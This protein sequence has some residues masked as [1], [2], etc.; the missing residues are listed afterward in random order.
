MRGSRSPSTVSIATPEKP[1]VATGSR[2]LGMQQPPQPLF[3]TKFKQRPPRGRCRG[4]GAP[5]RGWPC[6]DGGAAPRPGAAIHGT[7]PTL[8][9]VWRYRRHFYEARME[10]AD[11]FWKPKIQNASYG[12]S[13]SPRL[14]RERRAVRA[15]LCIVR[16]RRADAKVSP[17]TA[18]LSAG[19]QPERQSEV[20]A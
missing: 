5:R 8:R 15:A 10:I 1:V 12:R 3:Q 9:C 11:L 18:Q 2:A 17:H 7:Q 14:K 13:A 20:T 19:S 16:A 4:A 6:G